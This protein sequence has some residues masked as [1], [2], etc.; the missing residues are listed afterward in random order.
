L[1]DEYEC[2]EKFFK[3]K[4]RKWFQFFF[5]LWLHDLINK[6]LIFIVPIS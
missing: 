1:I 6:N 2:Y 3:N 4:R 5:S